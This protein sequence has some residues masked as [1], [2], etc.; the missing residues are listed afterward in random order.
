MSGGN[1]NDYG[2]RTQRTRD[3]YSEDATV[4]RRAEEERQRRM[5]EDAER[6]S[7]EAPRERAKPMETKKVEVDT[8]LARNRI[9]A[10]PKEAEELTILLI[11]H[12]ASNKLISRAVRQGG[13]YLHAILAAL[14]PRGTIAII[15]FSDHSDGDELMQEADYTIP[16]ERGVQILRA[17]IDKVR[18]ANGGDLPE[19]IECALLRASNLNF[20]KIPK[21]KRHLIL[22]SDQVA[23]GMSGK[24][25]QHDEG[26]PDQVHWKD[27][28]KRVHDAYS[29]FQ[30]IACGDQPH[31][32]E[33]QKQFIAPERQQ[34]DLVDM[35]TG[36]LTHDERC[37]LVTNFVLLLVARSRGEQTVEGF[38]LTLVEKWIAEP[39]YGAETIPRAKQQIKNFLQYIEISDRERDRRS[40]CTGGSS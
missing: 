33:L 37:R 19:A 12:S 29:T 10:P 24:G 38:L 35:S 9:G 39:Q 27:S 36:R 8:S 20:G 14:A 13:A 4:S 21:E 34:F 25:G 30:M 31:I 18:D 2:S 26:C 5:R 11:D 16:G 22:V 6:A 17:S 28:L 15:F 40:R 23:H 7:R 1:Y 32:F 3:I